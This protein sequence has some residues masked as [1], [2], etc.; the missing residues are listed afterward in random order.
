MTDKLPLRKQFY[1]E[2]GQT[3]F[4]DEKFDASLERLSGCIK[5]VTATLKGGGPWILGEQYTIADVVLFPSIVR[6]IDLKLEH[7]WSDSPEFE[8]WV[9]ASLARQAFETAFMPG[10]RI[11]LPTSV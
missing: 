6:M 2:M 4:T 11:S 8:A 3:G 9:D 7:L 1:K 10:S 5:R